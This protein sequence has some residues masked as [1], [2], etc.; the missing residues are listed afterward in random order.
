MYLLIDYIQTPL[1]FLVIP[2]SDERVGIYK[3]C[4]LEKDFHPKNC[5]ILSL[6][7]TEIF[8]FDKCHFIRV[9]Y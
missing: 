8:T 6:S 2:F 1:N 4:G 3:I 9:K 5:I 7:C